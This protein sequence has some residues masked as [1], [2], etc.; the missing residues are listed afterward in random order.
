MLSVIN[1]DLGPDPRYTWITIS[2]N[3]GGAII[4]TI[5]GRLS[6]L[7]GGRYFFI[8]GSIILL[9]GFIVVVAA[10]GIPQVCV[11]V[12]AGT[13]SFTNFEAAYC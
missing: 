13:W 2:W 6:D 3:L 10:K 8:A 1:E 11:Y 4:V 9:L 12:P 7:F 5:A